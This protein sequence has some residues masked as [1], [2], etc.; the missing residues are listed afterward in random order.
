[1][2]R[3]SVILLGLIL[4]VSPIL[5]GQYTESNQ[6]YDLNL[7]YRVDGDQ[8]HFTVDF[9]NKLEIKVLF[10]HSDIE[11]TCESGEIKI[12][13][14]LPGS[15]GEIVAKSQRRLGDEGSVMNECIAL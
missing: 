12:R 6:I 2:N 11:F 1:M 3:R 15:G 9:Q 13:S 14:L 8:L 5:A 4:A 7:D 10:G